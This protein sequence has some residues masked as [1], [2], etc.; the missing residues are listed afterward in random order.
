MQYASF[1]YLG[2]LWVA[3]L[4]ATSEV[5]FNHGQ[6]EKKNREHHVVLSAL[7]SI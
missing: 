7:I 2:V 6:L 1:F 4:R 5:L 3:N